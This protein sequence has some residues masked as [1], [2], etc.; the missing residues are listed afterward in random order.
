MRKKFNLFILIYHGDHLPI[1]EVAQSRIWI[2][3]CGIGI[4][5]HSPRNSKIQVVLQ[6]AINLLRQWDQSWS[7]VSAV[8]P[9]FQ[10]CNFPTAF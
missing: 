10:S 9:I 3:D 8:V 1:R 5:L 2:L 4:N 6:K 7:P